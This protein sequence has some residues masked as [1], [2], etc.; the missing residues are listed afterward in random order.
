ME[1][2]KALKDKHAEEIESCN[3]IHKKAIRKIKW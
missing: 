3:M 2:A 1:D